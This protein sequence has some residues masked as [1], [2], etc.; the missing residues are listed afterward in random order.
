MPLGLEQI[1]EAASQA[2]LFIAIGTSAVVYPAA[3]IVR[4]TKPSCRK[5]EINLDDTPNSS[6]FDESI[7]GKASVEVPAFL[8]SLDLD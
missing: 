8:K 6:E 1:Q 5:I 3:G 4:Q 2:D 7:R